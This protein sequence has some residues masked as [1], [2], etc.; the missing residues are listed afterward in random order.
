[1]WGACGVRGGRGSTRNGYSETGAFASDRRVSVQAWT[2]WASRCG[3]A[4]ARAPSL[5]HLRAWSTSSGTHTRAL[6]RLRRCDAARRRARGSTRLGRR[7]AL[8]I[9]RRV[10]DRRQWGKGTGPRARGVRHARALAGTDAMVG[11]KLFLQPPS[12]TGRAV[13]GCS[14]GASRCRGV[15]LSGIIDTLWRR[16]GGAEK[17]APL[18]QPSP[19]FLFV[20]RGLSELV[21]RD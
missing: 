18:N 14:C 16:P 1:V 3:R 6:A 15:R 19:H 5:V 8:E 10:G 2:S 11:P 21:Y 4:C 7:T 12:P 13:A 17:S 20:G 9:S